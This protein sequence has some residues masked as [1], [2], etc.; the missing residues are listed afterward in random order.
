MEKEGLHHEVIEEEL[1]YNPLPPVGE[2]IKVLPYSMM[3]VLPFFGI[4]FLFTLFA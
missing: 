1:G 3:A 2:F 4:M